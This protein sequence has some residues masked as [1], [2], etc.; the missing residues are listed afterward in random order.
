MRELQSLL[1]KQLREKRQAEAAA[2]VLATKFR[3]LK[4]GFPKRSTPATFVPKESP[5]ASKS[6]QSTASPI[7]NTPI[8]PSPPTVEPIMTPQET[9]SILHKVY[10]SSFNDYRA[11]WIQPFP[12]TYPETIFPIVHLPGFLCNLLSFHYEYKDMIWYQNKYFDAE[13][14]PKV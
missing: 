5:V 8:A 9:S 10:E 6:S 3:H 7:D 4:K 12:P 2:V 13:G 14:N 11:T 1:L